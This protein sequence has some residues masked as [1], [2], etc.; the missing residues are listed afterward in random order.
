MSRITPVFLLSLPRSGSTLVQRVLGAHPDVA[1]T[2]E[3]WLLLPFFHGF[4]QRGVYTT[5]NH[6]EYRKA[7]EDFCSSL[8]G[9]ERD[10]LQ[11]LRRFAVG[12]YEAASPETARYFVDKTP[13]YHT[14]AQL[15]MDAFE[16]AR[17][18]ILW[19]NPLAVASS[20][21]STWSD[22]R[23]NLYRFRTD[24]YAGLPALVEVV[25]QNPGRCACVRYED[26]LLAPGVH[27]RRL[28]DYLDLPF[29]PSLLDPT[30]KSE[31]KGRMGD[32]IGLNRYRGLSKE[33]LD[34]W[35]D[36]LA[37]PLRKRWGRRYL[38]W[39]GED[40]LSVMGY[41]LDELIAELDIVPLSSRFVASDTIR[42]TL[43]AL[44]PWLEPDIFRDKMR[45]SRYS[46]V[47]HG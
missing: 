13:R 22:G 47:A 44:Q 38:R 4:Q 26:L 5:Y 32:P 25:K 41:R 28:F 40:R 12:L 45:A 20:M 34:K 15:I 27:W 24:L 29:D 2:S 21:M 46:V 6:S 30:P 16:D 1:T 43:G 42:M 18:I 8:P 11:G 39:L 37:N 14:V 7:F 9:G 31:L 23:W 36:T 17:F 3:P 10:Y 35:K 33:P 19:R